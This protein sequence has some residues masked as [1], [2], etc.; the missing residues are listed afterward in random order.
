MV[1]TIPIE[2]EIV[3]RAG[4]FVEFAINLRKNST[5]T[6][7]ATSSPL[8]YAKYP[9]DKFGSER[10]IALEEEDSFYD[11]P[12][13]SPSPSLSSVSSET[14]T[15]LTT[16][17]AT[18]SNIGSYARIRVYARFA[19]EDMAT[20]SNSSS[21]DSSSSS[22]SSIIDDVKQKRLGD[23]AAALLIHTALMNA[24][25]TPVVHFLPTRSSSIRSS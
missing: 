13:P 23:S 2:I 21:S 5:T 3:R 15:P 14:T 20:K 8:L 17:T 18:C 12:K 24:T 22:S 25:V 19:F 16:M 7:T 9:T 6:T 1:P 10:C 4:S 11:R